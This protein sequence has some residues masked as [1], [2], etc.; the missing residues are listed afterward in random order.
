MTEMMTQM[1]AM[2]EM[3]QKATS[4]GPAPAP[5]VNHAASVAPA[6]LPN[7]HVPQAS[8]VKGVPEG[9]N[10]VVGNTRQRTP[11]NVASASEPV[12]AAQLE[13]LISEKI[14]AIITSKQAEK[15][16][17]KGRPYP[18]EYDQVIYDQGVYNA[19]KGKQPMQYEEKPKQLYTPSSQPKLVLGGNDKPQ[20]F[21]GGGER[22]RQATGAGE[23][24]ETVV[25]K[26]TVKMLKQLEGVP[27]VKWKSPTEPVLNLKWLPVPHAS[28]SKQQ[29][30]QA[31]SSKS[32]KKKAKSAKKKL[33]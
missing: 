19:D 11:Q 7:P 5:P 29:P 9:G 13:G 24:W 12:T 15:L 4:V 30:G 14:K 20:T 10:E 17:G 6:N 8:G 18:A 16:V 27:G 26:K 31:S 23:Q 22:P 1:T 32:D 28:T 3:M 2:M 33:R 25:S 21:S